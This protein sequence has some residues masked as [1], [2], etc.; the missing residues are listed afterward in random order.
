[1]GIIKGITPNVTAAL[2]IS[3]LLNDYN[4]LKLPHNPFTIMNSRVEYNVVFGPPP[5]NRVVACVGH[6]HVDGIVL[7]KHLSVHSD[8]RK[9]GLAT[10]L[11]DLVVK[12]HS[13]V[14]IK[15]HIRNDNMAS[16]H[17]AEKLGFM[18]T[19]WYPTVDHSVL[20]V[21]KE[22]KETWLTKNA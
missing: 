16:V 14:V 20:I 12:D 6:E 18:C 15:M 11:I 9:Q 19:S 7:I 13:N 21:E 2:D 5:E 10:T 3:L 17:L 8:Y 1:M 4:N 22:C